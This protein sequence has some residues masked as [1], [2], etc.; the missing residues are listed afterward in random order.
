MSTGPSEA[1]RQH[2]DVTAPQ[3]DARAFRQGWRVRSRLDV[4]LDEDAIEPRDYEA[5][6]T[7]RRDWEIAFSNRAPALM[8]FRSPSIGRVGA[9]PVDRLAALARLR[10]VADALGPF[11]CKLL[12]QCCVLDLAWVAIG[13]THQVADTTARRWTIAAL[14]RLGALP[15]PER[16]A[17]QLGEAGAASGD[18]AATT[19]PGTP[20]RRVAAS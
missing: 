2:H 18:R 1:Y 17:R 8:T 3:V 6:A 5:A 16:L 19:K 4:L 20:P 7:F 15:P 11:D 9:G 13:R 10:R 12:E 14:R